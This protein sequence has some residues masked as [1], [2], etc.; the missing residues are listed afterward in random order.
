MANSDEAEV[1]SSSNQVITTDLSQLSKDEC[2]DAM[3]DMSTELYHLRV[4][5]KSL[6][7]KTIE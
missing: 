7:K 4:S 3:N 2:N 1:S 5:L 6:T